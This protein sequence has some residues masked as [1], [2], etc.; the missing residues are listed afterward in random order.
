MPEPYVPSK[1][2]VVWLEFS[3]Q[4]GHE[5]SGHRP[6]LCISPLEYN[7]VVGL[8][9]FCPI[10]SQAKGYPFEVELPH[11]I[12]IAGVILSDHVKSLD[13]KARRAKYICPLPPKHLKEVIAKLRTLL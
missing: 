12:E 13:W 7:E 3:P 5:Q 1:G 10:T 8:A 9:I 4:A 11:S 2:D 6:A